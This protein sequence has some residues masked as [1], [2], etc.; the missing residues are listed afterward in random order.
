MK[1]FK[2]VYVE[3]Q[4]SHQIMESWIAFEDLGSHGSR[5]PKKCHSVGWLISEGA[6]AKVISPH[7]AHFPDQGCGIMTI[8][9]CSI[10][11]LEE[12]TVPEG[13]AAAA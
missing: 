13:K 11:R 12:L 3:W 6:G 7:L 9:D 1:Q 10:I 2:L 5:S 8:P 4:D